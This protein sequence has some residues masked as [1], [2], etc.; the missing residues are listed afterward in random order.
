[1]N[2]LFRLPSEKQ[3]AQINITLF[4]KKA[5]RVNLFISCKLMFNLQKILE[6]DLHFFVDSWPHFCFVFGSHFCCSFGSHFCCSFGS[7]F[8]CIFVAFLLDT[9]NRFYSTKYG[10]VL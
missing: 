1:M 8:C 3:F 5:K 10:N 9:V 6:P 7:H 2:K 4:F